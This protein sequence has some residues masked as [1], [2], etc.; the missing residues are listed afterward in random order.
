MSMDTAVDELTD[1]VFYAISNHVDMDNV[2]ISPLSNELYNVIRWK[3]E[4]L[5]KNGII[6]IK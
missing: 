1:A 6:D 2:R 5:V 4:E 3:L